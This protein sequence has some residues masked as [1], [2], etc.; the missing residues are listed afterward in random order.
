MAVSQRGRPVVAALRRA[1]RAGLNTQLGSSVVVGER[2]WDVEGK[3][4]VRVGPLGYA[5]F[6]RLMPSGDAL[7]PLCQMIRTYA[8]PQFDFDVQ[9]V[10]KAAEVPWCRLGGDGG[11]PS[12][13]GWNTWILS[14]NVDHDVS[15]AVFSWE[16]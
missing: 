4:R 12:R 9:V 6:R 8:G 10:L 5:G 15:D 14:A 3:F 16:G 2:V 13:L 7:R 11:D 1:G